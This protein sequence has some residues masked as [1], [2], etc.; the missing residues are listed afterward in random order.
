[1]DENVLELGIPNYGITRE[2]ILSFL[3]MLDKEKVDLKIDGNKVK[4]KS[5][6]ASL[7]KIFADA[8]YIA[9]DRLRDYIERR[10]GTEEVDEEPMQKKS[11]KKPRIDIP[12]SGNDKDVLTKVKKDLKIP[13]TSSFV[14]VFHYFGDHLKKLENNELQ[15]LVKKEKVHSPLSIFKPELYG[16]TRGPYFDGK[17]KSEEVSGEEAKLSTWEFLVRLAGYVISRVGVVMIP[18]G[19]KPMYLTVLAMPT[20]IGYRKGEFEL[21]LNSMKEFPGFNPEEGMIMWMA[22]NLPTQLDEVLVVGMKNPGG[23][24]PA[25]IKIGFNVPLASYRAKANN[26]LKKIEEYGSEK[27]LEWMIR[28]AMWEKEADTE[29]DLLKLLFLASQGDIRSRE[30][31]MLRASRMLLPSNQSLSEAKNEGKRKLLDYCK[32]ILWTIP[33]L[34]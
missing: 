1:M 28:T 12:A 6:C 22:M 23:M 20:D 33:L 15:M 31:L 10:S 30:E 2:Y 3:N 9:G 26:F 29:K 5:D 8:F 24:S 34:S 21:M 4:V 18:S 19:N 16:Y 7:P 13:T 27:S 25:E 11:A 14:D 17:L 32:N